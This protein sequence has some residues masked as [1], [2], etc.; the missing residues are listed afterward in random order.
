MQKARDYVEY[1]NVDPEKFTPALEKMAKGLQKIDPLTGKITEGFKKAHNALK[2]WANVTF[3]KVAQKI[4][5]LKKA[6]EGGFLRKESLEAEY[7]KVSSQ[8]KTQIIKELE[9]LK[10]SLSES[11]YHSVLASE[12][13]SKME[14]IGGEAFVKGMRQEFGIMTGESMG[15]II[16]RTADRTVRAFT[17]SYGSGQKVLVNGREIQ[18]GAQGFNMQN[19]TQALSP[20]VSGIQQLATQKQQTTPSVDYS[21]Y[22]A[23]I[24]A[25]LKNTNVSVQNVKVAVDNL[26]SNFTTIGEAIKNSSSSNGG[27]TYN[28]EIN[29]SGFSIQR[30]S[31]ADNV[32]RLT[33]SAI[34]Q[35]L[36]NGGL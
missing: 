17:N 8:V 33:E 24:I 3:D 35:G 19:F 5:K 22:I 31:D 36:G 11:Q 25:E 16:E 26:S 14:E 4:Q 7:Q 28:V 32:A 10:K 29:Q 9:P 34:R 2:E 6:V 21:S 12:F 30:K 1:L 13:A 27:N 15:A 23:S 18:Q 20:V